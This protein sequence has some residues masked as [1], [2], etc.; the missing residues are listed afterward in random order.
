MSPRKRDD[1]D[2]AEKRRRRR[3][4][5]AEGDNEN[6]GGGRENRDGGPRRK[7]LAINYCA[8]SR[9]SKLLLVLHRQ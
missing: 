8:T 9:R 2:E 1:L 3:K 6:G 4:A 5:D 7:I